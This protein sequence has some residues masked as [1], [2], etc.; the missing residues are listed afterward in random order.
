MAISLQKGANLNL[1]KKAP[2]VQQLFLGLGWDIRSDAGPD[3][4][5]DA[6]LLMLADNGLVRSDAD[7]IY[8]GHMRSDCGAVEHSGDNR[9]GVGEGDDEVLFINLEVLPSEISRLVVAVTIHEADARRQ[10]FGMI[11]SAFIRLVSS[12]TGAELIRFDLTTDFSAET[13]VIF[14]ELSRWGAGWKFKAVGLGY[15]GGLRALA[16]QHGVAVQ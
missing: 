10:H 4:D 3:F 12:E 8:Y 14:A 2:G 11:E 7:F 13:A 15:T 5:L 16:A 6:S 9:T 1:S